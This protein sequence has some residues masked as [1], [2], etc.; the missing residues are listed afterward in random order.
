MTWY[1]FVLKEN[2]ITLILLALLL[3]QLAQLLLLL[4]H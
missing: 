1:S 2:K 4:L 3:F